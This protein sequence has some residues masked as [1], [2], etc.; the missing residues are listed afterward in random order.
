M[1]LEIDHVTLAAPELDPLRQAF[2]DLG[3]ATDYGGPHSNGVTHMALLGL[4]DGSYVELISTLEAGNTDHDFWPEHIAGGAGPCAWAVQVDDVAKEA[5]RIAAL[6]IPVDGPAY[7]HRQRP[8]GVKVEWDLAFVGGGS[9][10][11]TLPFIIKDR[12][13]R[14]WRVSPSAS[15]AEARPG[16]PSG[17]ARVVLGIRHLDAAADLFQRVYEWPA[18]HLAD[19]LAF[20][21]RLA[22]FEGTPVS[23]ATPLSEGG[24]LSE[25]L[26]AF[27]DAPCAYLLRT[28]D[29]DAARARYGLSEPVTWLGHPVAWLDPERLN[30]IRLGFDS[31]ISF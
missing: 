26:D 15:V 21:A 5:A 17:V 8:D 7:Y 4:P 16:Q 11:A 27:G 18:P 3:L 28:H 30:G 20:G 22:H 2:A 1:T 24:W 10:G 31:R 13:P 12:T 9:P 23:L 29:L 25:R 6:G 14:E 19:D